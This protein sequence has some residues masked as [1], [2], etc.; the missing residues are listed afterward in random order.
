MKT[1]L[2]P[3]AIKSVARNFHLC[4]VRVH[5]HDDDLTVISFPRVD[6]TFEEPTDRH[7]DRV[8]TR[9]AVPVLVID[10]QNVLPDVELRG[11][12]VWGEAKGH[13]L[14]TKTLTSNVRRMFKE[15]HVSE[16][17]K[18]MLRFIGALKRAQ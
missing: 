2:S 11:E 10:R 13:R 5:P 14:G 9:K 17:R 8:V 3:E 6:Y 1:N 12:T 7:P 18:E 4:K 15:L 16:G